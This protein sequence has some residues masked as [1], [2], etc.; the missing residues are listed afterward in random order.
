MS[1][2][3]AE[4]NGG[5]DQ[6][7]NASRAGCV[8]ATELVSK[9]NGQADGGSSAIGWNPSRTASV[10]RT[11]T[12]SGSQVLRTETSADEAFRFGVATA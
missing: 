12:C 3:D 5:T 9:E 10:R 8:S 6:F 1:D 7:A 4:L 11:R 2:P